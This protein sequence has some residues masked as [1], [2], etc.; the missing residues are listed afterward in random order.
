MVLPCVPLVQQ[1]QQRSIPP[2]KALLLHDSMD[3][4]RT[5]NLQQHKNPTRAS[6]HPS[7]SSRTTPDIA[8]RRMK[9]HAGQQGTA[10]LTHGTRFVSRSGAFL[11]IPSSQQ[12]SS[13]YIR[14][15][16]SRW[17]MPLSTQSSSGLVHSGLRMV[18]FTRLMGLS[19]TEIVANE[20][21]CLMEMADI[22]SYSVSEGPAQTTKVVHANNRPERANSSQAQKPA[23]QT[24]EARHACAQKQKKQ[25]PRRRGQ[26]MWHATH[27]TRK[28]NPSRPV[29]GTERKSSHK[30]SQTGLV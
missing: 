20:D 17:S 23:Y 9:Q 19:L 2:K 3:L 16:S 24:R 27:K 12:Q 11:R 15:H 14:R 4:T 18:G 1:Q 28:R 29:K 25:T 26:R 22:S 5:M 10:E 8:A 6:M 7:Q 21:S 13:G 30:H